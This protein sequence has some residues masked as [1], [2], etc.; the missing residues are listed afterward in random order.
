VRNFSGTLFRIKISHS[1]LQRLF[2]SNQKGKSDAR[3]FF[4]PE[5][6]LIPAFLDSFHRKK[7][8]F[9]FSEALLPEKERVP[10]SAGLFSLEKNGFQALG[11]S[12]VGKRMDSRFSE[13]LFAGKRTDSRLYGLLFNGKRIDTSFPRLFSVN[14]ECR[15]CHFERVLPEKSFLPHRPRLRVPKNEKP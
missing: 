7:N 2:L 12:F 15:H 10:D 6:E 8:G 3:E 13:L 4:S 1:G 5:K 9:R 11:V 14:I